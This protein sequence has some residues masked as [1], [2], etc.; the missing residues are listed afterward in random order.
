LTKHDA[1]LIRKTTAMLFKMLALEKYWETFFPEE[2]KPRSIFVT[3]SRVLATKVAQEFHKY[4]W[5][6]QAAECSDEDLLQHIPRAQGTAEDA[7]L[8]H[9]DDTAWRDDLPR[10]FSAL[11]D[12]HFPLFVTSEKA[13]TVVIGAFL[14]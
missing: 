5:S 9:M 2:P 13:S 7:D 3:K 11:E 8:I 14:I 6:L 4:W 12:R 1:L 10:E